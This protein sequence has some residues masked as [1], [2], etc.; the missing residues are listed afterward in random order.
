MQ[1]LRADGS[2]DG[3][4]ISLSAVPSHVVIL[5]SVKDLGTHHRTDTRLRGGTRH[6]NG[7][8]FGDET[9]S[10]QKTIATERESGS[11]PTHSRHQKRNHV[12]AR[13][14]LPG[15]F[16]SLRAVQDDS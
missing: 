4:A 3:A 8:A 5:N 7:A 6:R 12:P 16:T 14:R 11:T 10:R 13:L 9:A 2:C 15:S 1:R